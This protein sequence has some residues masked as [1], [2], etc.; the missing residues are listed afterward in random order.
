MQ[1]LRYNWLVTDLD[2]TLLD[3]CQ[4][5][6]EVNLE[7]IAAFRRA[8]GRVTFATGRIELATAAYIEKLNIVEPCIL[9]N[10]ARIVDPTTGA[11]LWERQLPDE[12]GRIVADFLSETDNSPFNAVFYVDGQPC[13]RALNP[14]LDAY[15]VKDGLR[16]HVDPTNAFV[17]NGVTKV[18]L[19]GPET[20]MD[21]L[22]SKL[23]ARLTGIDLVRSEPQYLEVL[24]HGCHKGAALHWL[25]EKVGFSLETT[26]A[27]G[28]NMNDLEM[29][30]TAGLG[31]AVSN[32]NPALR[33]V[34]DAIVGPGP[35][36]GVAEAIERY[37]FAGPHGS[38]ALSEKGSA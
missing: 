3:E 2:G 33:T 37:C 29:L 14:V 19:I 35:K 8:G 5:I 31:V 13:V 32:A 15:A 26:L 23:S 12:V 36:G 25:A 4:Q 11:V 1:K 7:T 27:I 34:A 17:D 18:L 21:T 20:K 16:L 24:P 30:Q 28:D 10:G 9:Y 22:A 6:P 38:A